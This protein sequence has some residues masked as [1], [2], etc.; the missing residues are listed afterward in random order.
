MIIIFLFLYGQDLLTAASLA[1]APLTSG[2]LVS[3]ASG[4]KDN[5]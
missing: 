5:G 2:S 4:D 1:S 3:S